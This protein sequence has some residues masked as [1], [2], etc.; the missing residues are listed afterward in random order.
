MCTLSFFAICVLRSSGNVARAAEIQRLSERWYLFY[1]KCGLDPIPAIKLG[2]STRIPGY[3]CGVRPPLI[4]AGEGLKR[5]AALL[6]QS[7]IQENESILRLLETLS[8]V[9]FRYF[10]MAFPW[11]ARPH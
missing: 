5:E 6:M 2:I 4:A 10:S 3:P 7:L 8:V 1:R 9:A 11:S